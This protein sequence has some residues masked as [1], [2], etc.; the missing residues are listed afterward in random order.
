VRRTG[1]RSPR[2]RPVAGA[3]RRPRV[4]AVRRRPARRYDRRSATTTGSLAALH[5]G[6]PAFTG[7]DTA[8]VG[9]ILRRRALS[10]ARPG[11]A[12]R[13]RNTLRG[14]PCPRCRHGPNHE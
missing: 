6:R 4:P 14:R 10:H 2:A 8:A 12:H 7:V 1:G 9:H 13:P 5:G 11:A 3:A